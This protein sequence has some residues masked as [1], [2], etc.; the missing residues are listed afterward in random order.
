MCCS[1]VPENTEIRMQKP[2]RNLLIKKPTD[3]TFSITPRINFETDRK[4][5]QK[6]EYEDFQSDNNA[7]ISNEEFVYG[8]ID[9]LTQK[10]NENNLCFEE[11]KDIPQDRVK[12]NTPQNT[13]NNFF[14]DNIITTSIDETKSYD[15]YANKNI[16]NNDVN[17]INNINEIYEKTKITYTPVV[18]KKNNSK[19]NYNIKQDLNIKNDINSIHKASNKELFETNNDKIYQIKNN[20]EDYNINNN[21]T[22]NLEDNQSLSKKNNNTNLNSDINS[23]VFT[24][25]IV[26]PVINYNYKK[27]SENQISDYKT[28]ENKNNILDKN[29]VPN[30]IISKTDIDINT[31]NNII[32][33][34]NII[35]NDNY[36]NDNNKIFENINVV[37]NENIIK[38]DKVVDENEKNENN[39][40]SLVKVSKIQTEEQFQ[41]NENVRNNN[42]ISSY[43]IYN[44]NDIYHTDNNNNIIQNNY[45]PI[46]NNI[47]EVTEEYKIDQIIAQP[48]PQMSFAPKENQNNVYET[49]IESKEEDKKQK[50]NVIDNNLENIIEVQN[51]NNQKDYYNFGYPKYEEKSTSIKNSKILEE[52]GIN[53]QVIATEKTYQK[54]EFQKKENNNEINSINRYST[55]VNGEINFNHLNNDIFSKNSFIQQKSHEKLEINSPISEL[56]K[57]ELNQNNYENKKNNSDLNYINK[58]N[59]YEKK[60]NNKISKNN[61]YRQN[62]K[63][64]YSQNLDI[65]D[66]NKDINKYFNNE[67]N[68]INKKDIINNNYYMNSN[69]ITNNNDIINY[70]NIEKN[71]HKNEDKMKNNNNNNFITYQKDNTNF[72]NYK[73]IIIDDNN[74]YPGPKDNINN[75]KNNNDYISEINKNNK[76]NIHTKDII[77][78]YFINPNENTNDKDI[79][80][81]NKINKYD[82]IN[83]NNLTNENFNY[84]DNIKSLNNKEKNIY[85]NPLKKLKNKKNNI[86]KQIISYTTTDEI[87]PQLYP[88]KIESTNTDHYENNIECNSPI[89]TKEQNI[90]YNS[91]SIP[92]DN[93]NQYNIPT[94]IDNLNIDYITE[95]KDI[96]NDVILSPT[97]VNKP[98]FQYNN[99]EKKVPLTYSPTQALPPITTYETSNEIKQTPKFKQSRPIP[100]VS[101]TINNYTN[102][103]IITKSKSYNIDSFSDNGNLENKNPENK[104]YNYISN[105]NNTKDLNKNNNYTKV[106]S[107]QNNYQY[108]TEFMAKESTQPILNQNYLTSIQNLNIFSSG[109]YQIDSER[110]SRFSNDNIPSSRNRKPQY[111]KK[112][113][114]IYTA[115]LDNPPRNKRVY[116]N[117]KLLSSNLFLSR[118]NGNNNMN[119]SPFYYQ[120]SLSQDDLGGQDLRNDSKIRSSSPNESPLSAPRTN[121]NLN[122][123]YLPYQTT[124]LRKVNPL[125]IEVDPKSKQIINYYSNMNLAKFATFSHDSFKLFY[126]QNERFFKIPKNE[127]YEEKEIVTY[128]NNDP[129]L[130]EVY[131]GAVN[132]YGIKHGQGKLSTPSAK[133]IG[134]WRNG[135][136][137]G[138]GRE[139]RNTGEVFEGKFNDGKLTGKGIYKYGDILYIGDFVNY[140]REGKGEKITRKYYY[141]GYFS[142]NKIDGYGRIQFINSEDGESEYEGFFKENNIEGKGIMKWKNGNI[143]EGE[144]KDNTMN[145]QGTLRLNNG[146][147]FKGFFKDGKFAGNNNIN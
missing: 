83:V 74:Y 57:N 146:L 46:Q 120:R 1:N 11:N 17:Q 66:Y 67:K 63:N 77:E 26:T 137:T 88:N 102:L 37:S 47:N 131:K 5:N 36:K 52:L 100:K 32:P 118:N 38:K 109:N 53:K 87:T 97:K 99:V 28:E 132:Q 115:S 95:T 61:L 59:V 98:I 103:D 142:N 121:K 134:T 54:F 110:S 82:N 24:K 19:S 10:K 8:R 12:K 65:Y 48:E 84:Y 34:L 86:E 21:N 130:K 45:K 70:Y 126:P 55:P 18:I 15:F 96:K 33:N 125:D 122:A 43:N 129:N 116:Q 105:S 60:N 140:L 49:V 101:K 76:N 71:S 14:K 81:E 9:S 108:N 104:N 112:G 144:M 89:K 143:Y 85:Q 106:I 78:T 35:Q 114:P 4:S 145:G 111:D 29:I 30:N 79:I 31:N 147:T 128:I 62:K 40:M 113:N 107:D 139:I 136:F 124:N 51:T 80:H 91:P 22:Y 64:Y 119:Y 7:I 20:V 2:E 135:K 141:V 56:S 3:N 117:N 42:I 75:I 25:P 58:Y 41:S 68:N 93:Y 13:Y 27:K 133:I 72:K 16:E 23:K 90:I 39:F 138:W 69:E 50:T 6:K 44:N 92:I 123:S 73:E 94:K 127:I